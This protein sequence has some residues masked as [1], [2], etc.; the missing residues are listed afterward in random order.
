MVLLAISP[1]GR[2]ENREWRE[3]GGC[4]EKGN[5]GEEAAGS[6]GSETAALA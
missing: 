1:E 2:M 4:D 5:E 3:G 6:D